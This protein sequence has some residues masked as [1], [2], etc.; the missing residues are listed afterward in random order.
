MA[1]ESKLAKEI[2]DLVVLKSPDVKK[3]RKLLLSANNVYKV[4]GWIDPENVRTTAQGQFY[5]SH[6]LYFPRY[7]K[8][9]FESFSSAFSLH[10]T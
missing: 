6:R 8:N 3:L 7:I 1:D 10:T 2:N 5:I 9:V 4:V